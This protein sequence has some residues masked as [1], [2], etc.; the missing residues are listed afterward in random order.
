MATSGTLHARERRTA[1]LEMLARDGAVQLDGAASSLGVSSMTVRRD[2]EDLEA[3]GLLR[4]VRGGAVA[5]IAP[6]PFGERRAV[7]AAAKRAIARKAA[8]LVPQ[9]GAVAFDASSTVGMLGATLGA[10]AALTVVTNSHDTFVAL[11]SGTGVTPVLVGGVAEPTT[12]SFVGPVATRAASSMLYVRLF[13]SASAVDP[14]H[15]S[16]EVSLLESE[17][18]HAFAQAARSTVLCI[19]ST[20]LDGQSLA[21]GFALDEVEVMITELDPAHP[22]LDAYRELV[23]LR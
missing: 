1:L 4:R 6:L 23:D 21:L 3:E 22:A 8:D 9:T 2:L 18:K 13:C 14:A 16:S 10:R 7:R 11:S 20:K 19:D 15:G 12:G 5:T 17:V